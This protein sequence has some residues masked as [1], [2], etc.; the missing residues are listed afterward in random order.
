MPM[1]KISSKKIEKNQQT[2]QTNK[3]RKGI[4]LTRKLDKA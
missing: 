4:P 2:K 1:K 3:Q